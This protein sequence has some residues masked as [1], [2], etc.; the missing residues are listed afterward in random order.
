MGES[1]GAR[2]LSARDLVCALRAARSVSPR[3]VGVRQLLDD[4][5]AKRDAL[6]RWR[7]AH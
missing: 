5:R 4:L 7:D 3:M 2:S 1:Q 6:L